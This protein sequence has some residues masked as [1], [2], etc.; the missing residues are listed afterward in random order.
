MILIDEPIDIFCNVPG[1]LACMYYLVNA[2]T[3]C[4][5]LQKLS[6]GVLVFE[7]NIVV[8]SLIAPKSQ[9]LY[10]KQFFGAI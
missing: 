3:S 5:H 7:R 9:H 10:L 1:S 4:C 2:H 6:A 8:G